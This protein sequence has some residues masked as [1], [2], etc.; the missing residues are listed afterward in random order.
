[1]AIRFLTPSEESIGRLRRMVAEN[2]I[3]DIVAEQDEPV[4][5]N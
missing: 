5:R 2:L 4:I 3:G 1:M